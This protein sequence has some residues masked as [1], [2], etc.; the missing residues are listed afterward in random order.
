MIGLGEYIVKELEAL[1]SLR[2]YRAMKK[3]YYDD[4]WCQNH[5]VIVDKL[6]DKFI[7]INPI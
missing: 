1:Y 7:N 4:K 5:N 6:F 2:K 3:R